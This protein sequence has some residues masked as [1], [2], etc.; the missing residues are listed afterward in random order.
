MYIY[1]TKFEIGVDKT[2]NNSIWIQPQLN[3]LH[4]KR[5]H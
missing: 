4:R 5:N 3:L 1:P 2:N